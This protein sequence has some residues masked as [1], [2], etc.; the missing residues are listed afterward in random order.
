MATTKRNSM[1]RSED[2]D[3]SVLPGQLPFA[4]SEHPQYYPGWEIACRSVRATVIPLLIGV[5]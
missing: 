3:S 4:L 5:G 1:R 2:A